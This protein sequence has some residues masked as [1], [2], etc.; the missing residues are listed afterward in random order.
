MSLGDAYT[1]IT[2]M[3]TNQIKTSPDVL[4]LVKLIRMHLLDKKKDTRNANPEDSF[5]LG[6]R[7]WVV[8]IA[9]EADFAYSNATAR[10][11]RRFEVGIGTGSLKLEDCNAIEGAVTVA[12]LHLWRGQDALGVPTAFDIS[13]L[14]LESVLVG[15][16]DSEREPIVD[17]E[18]VQAICEVAVVAYGDIA[19]LAP[20]GS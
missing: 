11:V 20:T 10:F 3:I 15:Q 19:T 18:E 14:E 7:I 9:S 16:V 2:R 8:P 13:P 1:K 5:E 6:D 12:M 4:A 17:P